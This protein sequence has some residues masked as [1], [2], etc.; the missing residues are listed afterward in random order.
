MRHLLLVSS[1]LPAVGQSLSD[2]GDGSPSL[3]LE[4]GP[5]AGTVHGSATDHTELRT[6]LEQ[7]RGAAGPLLARYART[8]YR[9]TQVIGT[10]G[11]LN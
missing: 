9:R 10:V 6:L 11:Q 5:D 4:V 1:Y 3:F 8:A 2:F 7:V